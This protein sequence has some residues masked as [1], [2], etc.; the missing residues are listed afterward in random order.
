MTTKFIKTLAVTHGRGLFTAEY[1]EDIY[2]DSNNYPS[3]SH[4]VGVL[5]TEHV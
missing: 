1:V 3:S 4:M 5:S 2:T